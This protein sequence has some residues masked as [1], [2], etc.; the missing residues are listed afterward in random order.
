[1]ML[2]V[3][4]PGISYEADAEETKHTIEAVRAS[5]GLTFGRSSSARISTERGENSKAAENWYQQMVQSRKDRQEVKSKEF[6]DW[7]TS[8]LQDAEKRAQ[9]KEEK[10][11]DAE[12]WY[13][14][15]VEKRKNKDS[16]D[17]AVDSGAGVWSSKKD[18]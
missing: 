5:F 16:V 4:I 3:M 9:H 8:K 10:K 12:A 13:Q 15:E 11:Q 18:T 1:M 6:E 7:E 14:S 17:S 2:H